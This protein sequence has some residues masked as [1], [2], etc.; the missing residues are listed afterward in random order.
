MKSFS[1]AAAL[2]VVGCL[3]TTRVDE[4]G[5]GPAASSAVA[6]VSQSS[7]G[8]SA[9]ASSSAGTGG[10]AAGGAGGGCS[11]PAEVMSDTPLAYWRL[12]ETTTPVAVDSSGHGHDGSYL[13]GVTPGL[14]G[15]IG[16]AAHFDGNGAVAVDDNFDF[17]GNAP[18][19]LEA[20]YRPDAM[21][22]GAIFSKL[23][24]D[25]MTYDGYVLNFT[26]AGQLA[27]HR[28]PDGV[29]VA[30]APSITS[31]THVVVTYDTLSM[32]LYINGADALSVTDLTLLNDVSEAFLIGDGENWSNFDGVIDEVAIYGAALPPARILAHYQCATD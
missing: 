28:E 6:T 2:L 18:F 27:F 20:W 7:T 17:P 26:M 14:P 32:R 25:G 31:F 30:M 16:T 12:D 23:S 21:A 5:S 1:T 13:A 9:V 29:V 11:Y 24:W 10:S 19:S 15:A 8:M 22:V 4:F 3:A